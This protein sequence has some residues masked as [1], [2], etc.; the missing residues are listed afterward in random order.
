[1]GSAHLG[2]DVVRWQG[3]GMTRFEGGNGQ[4]EFDGANVTI[5]R[6]GGMGG[7]SELPTTT[8][9]IADIVDVLVHQPVAIMK[10]WVYVATAGHESMPSAT[11]VGKNAYAVTLNKKQAQAVEE[12]RG[13]ILRAIGKG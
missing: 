11:E 1:M 13:E 2:E 9:P 5:A 12:V 4:I 7:F 10:G 6:E 8:I 3:V